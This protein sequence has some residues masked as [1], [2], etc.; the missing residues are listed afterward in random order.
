[1]LHCIKTCSAYLVLTK[2]E[3][4]RERRMGMGAVRKDGEKLPYEL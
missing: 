4:E 3:G 2:K 1:M